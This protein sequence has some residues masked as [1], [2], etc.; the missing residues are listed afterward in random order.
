[1]PVL[2]IKFF[3]SHHNHHMSGCL[4]YTYSLILNLKALEYCNGYG[5]GVI[6]EQTSEAIHHIFSGKI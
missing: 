3:M 5:L 1:M 6:S 4:F 2:K